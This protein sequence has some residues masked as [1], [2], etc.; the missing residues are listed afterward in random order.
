[1]NRPSESV[2]VLLGA[3]LVAAVAGAVFNYSRYRD[4]RD[5]AAAQSELRESEARQAAQLREEDADGAARR[6]EELARQVD[7]LRTALEAARRA[8]EESD[9]AN[10]AARQELKRLT[11]G[12][13]GIDKQTA[14]LQA[15]Y[16]RAIKELEA[17]RQRNKTL[18]ADRLELM[19]SR[20]QARRSEL[21]A[22]NEAKR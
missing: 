15:N 7:S 16:D 14:T 3:V 4:A 17:V 5:M 21:A 9:D 10:R 13:A 20:E 12:V 8:Q 11:T 22:K 19:V 1:M 2:L 6:R 18:E